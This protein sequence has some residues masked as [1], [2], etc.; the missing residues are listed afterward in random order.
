MIKMLRSALLLSLAAL[1]LPAVSAPLVPQK[2]IRIPGG[3]GRF[4]YMMVDAAHHRLFATHKGVKKLAVLNLLTRKPLPS[5]S[6]GTTQGIQVD[7]AANAVLLGGEDE[8]RVL[9]LNRRT[10]SIQAV[11]PVPGPVDAIALDTKNGLLYADHDDHAQIYVVD[12]HHDKLMHVYA[13]P[14]Q[15][16][17]ICYDAADNTIYQNVKSTNQLVAMNPKTGA[18]THKWSTLPATLPHGLAIDEKTGMAFSAG[19]NGKLVVFNLS[20][21][22]K[23]ATVPIAAH[24]D[25]IIFDPGTKRVYCACRRAISVVQETASGAK[26]LGSAAVPANSHTLAVDPVTHSVWTT[27]YDKSGS[28]FLELKVH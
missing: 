9:I 1:S 18:I 2:P 23:I 24:V 13:I 7:A 8:K 4:D 5:P 14:G 21:G 27:Y 20:T 12:V 19:V 10:L 3:A 22:K 25:Q 6:V 28:Y 16:E 11:V 15:P 26:L 17:Y